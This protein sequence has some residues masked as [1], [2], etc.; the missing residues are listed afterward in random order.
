[1]ESSC[2]HEL[3]WPFVDVGHLIEGRQV[4]GGVG[5]TTFW[6]WMKLV[7]LDEKTCLT[8]NPEKLKLLFSQK[9]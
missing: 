1:M 9:S 3:E 8:S 2:C 4:S 6:F 7:I 5:T